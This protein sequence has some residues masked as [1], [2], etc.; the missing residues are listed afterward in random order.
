L[1]GSFQ[2]RQSQSYLSDMIENGKAYNIVEQ[3]NNIKKQ[4]KNY[5]NKCKIIGFE[6]VSRHKRS[7]IKDTRKNNSKK[8]RTNYKVFIKYLPNEN[9]SKAIKGLYLIS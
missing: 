1:F 9:N 3:T 6:I 2:L 8:F 5:D 4:P 7:E